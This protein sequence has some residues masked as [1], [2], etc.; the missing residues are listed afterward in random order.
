[1]ALRGTLTHRKT[2]RLASAL[3]IP[4]C[5]ALGVLESLW[6]V[7]AE[8]S[9]DGAIGRMSNQ[10]IADEIFWDGDPEIL[11]QALIS[12]G[13][14]DECQQNRLVVHDWS[15]HC[16]QSVRRKLT[17][18]DL[19]FA[20]R[21]QL[22]LVMAGEKLGVA[23]LPVPVPESRVQ[24][25]VPEERHKAASAACEPVE[26]LMS[27]WNELAASCGLASVRAVNGPRRR[28][29]VL[30]WR[31][32]PDMEWWRS[33][34]GTIPTTPFLCGHNGN[35]WRASFDW[36]MKPGNADRVAEGSYANGNGLAP[37]LT[38]V[39]RNQSA[40]DQVLGT[41]E[42]KNITPVGDVEVCREKKISGH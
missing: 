12:A 33:A 42:P 17:R 7:T 19:K 30:R 37:K 41:Q 21:E 10:D 8:Q 39:E 15:A 13:W 32:H 36:L 6:H 34:L 35:G 24:S 31:D 27:A 25:P 38:V 26:Q 23:S 3:Q 29:V 16:D 18:H 28:A 40:F 11:V 20:S 4:P 5:Y 22:R 9:P 1:M 2:R 14:I